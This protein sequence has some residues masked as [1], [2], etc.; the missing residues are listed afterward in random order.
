[1]M[2]QLKLVCAR[3]ALPI[4]PKEMTVDMKNTEMEVCMEEGFMEDFMVMVTVG[5]EVSSHVER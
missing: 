3:L 2:R 5:E 1:F 4:V